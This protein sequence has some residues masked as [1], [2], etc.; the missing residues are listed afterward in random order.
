MPAISENDYISQINQNGSG[1]NIPQIVGAI[2]DAEITPQKSPVLKNQEKVVAAISGLA[3][4]KES[5]ELTQKNINALKSN[6]TSITTKSTD[7]DIVEVE[8]TNQADIKVGVSKVTAI[9]QLAT[10]MSHS[11]PAAGSATA[12]FNGANATLAKPYNLQIQFGTYVLTANNQSF[13]RDAST[14]SHT[15]S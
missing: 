4:L 1:L 2:V 11:I 15:I 5:A 9:S 13:A 14:T 3:V 12:A 7:T 8:V 6:D 10:A